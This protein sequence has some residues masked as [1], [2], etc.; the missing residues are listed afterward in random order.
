MRY[1]FTCLVIF[2]LYSCD[3]QSVADIDLPPGIK[4]LVVNCILQADSVIVVDISSGKG[5]LEPEGQYPRIEN[6][7]VTIRSSNETWQL[8]HAGNGRYFSEKAVARSGMY[9]EIEVR[10]PSFETVYSSTV[11][12]MPVV[13]EEA[14]IGGSFVKEGTEYQKLLLTFRDPL[15]KNYYGINGT[16]RF[17]YFDPYLNQTIDRLETI[18]FNKASPSFGEFITTTELILDDL[19][20]SGRRHTLELL[21]PKYY[22]FRYPNS[23]TKI[24]LVFM[25]LHH[26]YFQYKT[27]LKLQQETANDPFA[28]PVIVF[29]NIK[30]GLGIF[31]ASAATEV[32]IIP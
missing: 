21:V 22:I 11:V 19:L 28:Q 32:I 30:N 16:A 15:A 13:I 2:A 25:H 12:P 14:T 18:R 27:T 8:Q 7:L 4:N 3:F 5:I 26:D 9:Y 29:N 24:K 1:P 23:D 31:S 6:A 10:S 17:T 20:F